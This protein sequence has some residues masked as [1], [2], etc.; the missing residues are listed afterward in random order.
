[1]RYRC[2]YP[3]LAALAFLAC[4]SFFLFAGQKNYWESKPYTEWSEKEVDRLLKDSPWTK[5]VLLNTGPEGMSGS[6]GGRGGGDEISTGNTSLPRAT[7]RLVVTWVARPIREAMARRLMLTESGVSKERIEK[8]L[9]P[10][11]QFLALLVN[12]WTFGRQAD[13][14]ATIASFKQETMLLKKNKEKILLA[15]TV[16][17][18]KRD[19]PLYL[20]FAREAGGKPVLTLADQEVTLVIRVG[21]DTYRIKFKLEDMLI[22]DK[23]EL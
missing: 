11:A 19:E 16:F 8:L 21:E 7:T 15:D 6:G 1:M 9:N 20:R 18:Q 23:L 12:G 4:G 2:L 5:S 22:D 17:P 14:N 10:N 3:A 13:R